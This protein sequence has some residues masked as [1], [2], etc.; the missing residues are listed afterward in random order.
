MG[1]VLTAGLILAAVQ[2]GFGGALR[3]APSGEV[4]A[5]AYETKADAFRRL[6][7]RALGGD[8]AAQFQ[9]GRAYVAGPRRPED[10]AE[11]VHWFRAAAQRGHPR[12]QSDLAVLYGKGL[13]VPLDY[14]RAYAWF[15]V[16]ATGFAHGWRRE[17]A[18]ELRDMLAAF[19]TPAQRDE[20]GRLADAWKA[21]AQ[22]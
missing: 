19:M 20:A 7:P 8:A 6:L 3:A 1:T 21:K 12:A 11:A 2:W 15:D 10:Y 4:P 18:L 13:G 17:Q 16:A 22:R 9:L 14:V 5:Q